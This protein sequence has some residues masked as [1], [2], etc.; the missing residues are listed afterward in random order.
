MLKLK[1]VDGF[2]IYQ[3]KH[4][5]NLLVG[6]IQDRFLDNKNINGDFIQIS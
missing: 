5:E 1:I 2:S 4:F 6:L 3:R